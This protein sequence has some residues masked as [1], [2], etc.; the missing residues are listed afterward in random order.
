M[1]R[2]KAFFQLIRLPN[3]VFIALTQIL[4]HFFV[5][6]PVLDKG[7]IISSLRGHNLAILIFATISITAAGYI[8]NDYFDLNGDLIRRPKSVVIGKYIHR[9]WA[10]ACHITMSLFGIALGFYLDF[11]S[12]IYFLGLF[13]FCCTFL[14]FVYSIALKKRPLLGNILISLL[15]S[16]VIIV[17]T[18]CE[19]L[20][21][22]HSGNIVDASK[23]TRLTLMYAGFAFI[24]S[25][26]REALKDLEDIDID[27]KLKYDTMPIK[28]GINASRVFII[29]WMIVMIGALAA[30]FFYLLIIKRWIGAGYCAVFLIAPMLILFFKFLKAKN[31]K[32]FKW[33][34]SKIKWVM[35][36]GILSMLIIQSKY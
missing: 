15:T 35:L 4:F 24:I 26:I 12:T 6:R 17:C 29:V 22:Y 31:R 32:D 7:H 16:W 28:W 2:F 34:R 33:V 5:I 20:G 14:L 30:F 18:W 9:H 1:K 23:I 19:T 36:L 10:L 8:I 25:I 13:N 27:R 11:T 21:I 3:L